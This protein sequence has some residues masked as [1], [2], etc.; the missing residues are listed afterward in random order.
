MEVFIWGGVVLFGYQRAMGWMHVEED[1]H[2]RVEKRVMCEVRK[3]WKNLYIK[4]VH[5]K[6]KICKVYASLKNFVLFDRFRPN[7][8]YVLQIF[9]QLNCWSF[10]S[11]RCF[12]L[13]FGS[14]PGL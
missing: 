7:L 2:N 13:H 12:L 4:T 14:L 8:P 1:E 6:F 5:G 9:E 3:V 10:S 11:M